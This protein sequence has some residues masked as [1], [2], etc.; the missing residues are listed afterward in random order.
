MNLI[1]H[2]AD[3]WLGLWS[4]TTRLMAPQDQRL[5]AQG[6]TLVER[7]S[8]RP[9]A[10]TRLGRHPNPGKPAI[11]RDPIGIATVESAIPTSARKM[12]PTRNT[13]R[14]AKRIAKPI[15]VSSSAGDAS[16]TRNKTASYIVVMVVVPSGITTTRQ[17]KVSYISGNTEGKRGNTN[18]YYRAGRK[19]TSLRGRLVGNRRGAAAT[20]V[21]PEL[22]VSGLSQ[23]ADCFFGFGGSCG[24]AREG[25]AQSSRADNGCAA[26]RPSR[27]DPDRAGRRGS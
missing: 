10:T 1:A 23:G 13:S 19:H 15:H 3:G 22:P 26:S 25:Y 5:T 11:L 7:A 12:R 27:I 18:N 4:P 16:H 2:A 14:R 17:N 8:H 9:S 24:L 21:L 20:A 6:K